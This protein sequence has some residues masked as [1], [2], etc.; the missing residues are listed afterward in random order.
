MLWSS[1]ITGWLAATGAASPIHRVVSQRFQRH[2]VEGAFILTASLGTTIPDGL[3][4]IKV[5]G[6]SRTSN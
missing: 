1:G 6:S 5:I 2:P 4:T 3:R